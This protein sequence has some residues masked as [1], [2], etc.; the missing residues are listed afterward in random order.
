MGSSIGNFTPEE[1]CD[2]IASWMSELDYADLMLVALDG[3]Q[4][5]ARVYHAYNDRA[6]VTHNFTMNG[7]KHANRLLGYE[8][9]KL[10]D[11]EAVGE[12]D[13]EGSRHRAFVVP[14]TD[15]NVEGVL[16][17]KGE[18]LQIEESNKWPKHQADRLWLN[19]KR[20]GARPARDVIEGSC[21][22]NAEG[23][24]CKSS[25]LRLLTSLESMHVDAAILRHLQNVPL[26]LN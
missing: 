8:A 3:C 22:S 4:D 16:I 23:S 10:S 11:W 5:P 12:Y 9:F 13:Q 14:N 19:A 6:G 18:K 24:Y 21:F 25:R 20:S 1:A 7:L 2:F 17:S 15:V 26:H